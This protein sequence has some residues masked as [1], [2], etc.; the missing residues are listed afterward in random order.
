[1][2]KKMTNKNEFEIVASFSLKK[3]LPNYQN[4]DGFASMKK[5]FPKMPDRK[6]ISKTYAELYGM[7]QAEVFSKMI[8]T[9]KFITN[10]RSATEERK[11]NAELEFM[12]GLDPQNK[13][14]A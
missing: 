6:E 9:F 8:D 5:T 2:R 10:K 13:D 3:S 4:F 14:L 11:E 7:C 12:G 1:M